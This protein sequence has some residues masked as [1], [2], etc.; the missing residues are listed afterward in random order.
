MRRPAAGVAGVIKTV[1]ALQNGLLP[2]TLHVDEPTPYVEWSSG[3]VELLTENREWPETGRPR[4]AGVSAFGRE[5]HQRARDSGGGEAPPMWH[6]GAWMSLMPH[7][8]R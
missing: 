3:A 5:R 6:W 8:G 1:L 7:W 4:R 2:K